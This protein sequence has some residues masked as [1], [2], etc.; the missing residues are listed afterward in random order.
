M[1][2]ICG[3]IGL[4]GR[5]W[6]VGDLD[7][8]LATLAPL[9]PDGG[10]R[11]AGTA[12]RCGVAVAAALRHAVPEDGFDVQP[13][14]NP[15]ET[16]A[17]VADLRLDNRDELSGLLGVPDSRS[18]P[19]SAFVLAGYERW[20]E[21]VLERMHGE[22]ALAIVDRRRGG[23]LLARDHVGARPLVVHERPHVVAFAS[24]ALALTGLEG[25]GHALDVRRAVEVLALA[26]LSERTFVQRVR[27]VPPATTLW[28]DAAG[29]RRRTWWQPD[30]FEIVDLGSAAAHEEELRE[31][32][33]VAV[34]ARLRTTRGVAASLSGGLDST[35]VAATAA[36]LLAPETL[37]TYTSAPPPGWNGD[38]PPGWDLDESPLVRKLAEMHPNMRPSFIH[39]P[40]GESVFALHDR[41][42]E[43]GSAPACN[44]CNMLW[45]T[46]M[47]TRAG[48]E[49]ASMMLS[50]ARGNLQFSADGPRWIAA[51]LH[52]GRVKTAFRE[53][54]KWNADAGRRLRT[55]QRDVVY[56]LLPE[57]AQRLA[58]VAYGKPERRAEWEASVALRPQF[59]A[60]LDMPNLLPALAPRPPDMRQLGIRHVQMVSTDCDL[61]AA[62]AIVTGVEERDPTGDRRVLAATIRQPEWVRR[63]D[64][65]T[66]AVVRGAM[67]DRLPPEI[68]NRTE[69]GEQLPDWFDVMTAARSELAYELE[70]LEEHD[71]S[72]L[73]IDTARLRKLGDGWPG[74]EAGTDPVTMRNYR[75][76]LFRA[77]LVSRYLRWFER[78]ARE[79]E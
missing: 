30:P 51:L 14:K 16:L 78:R 23:V 46:A 45:I 59:I 43:L 25:V 57:W 52:A 10:G 63:H 70:Q 3:V 2:A 26:F 77:L 33:D 74:L 6:A 60:E 40:R 5:P 13:A 47:R 64:R 11:W 76:A 53:A 27:W 7:G 50:G 55:L 24:N 65:T 69:R 79:R 9:G 72:R 49:G 19:D 4:D 32:L 66:R 17:L 21:S 42:W 41:L 1:S 75:L 71:T 31:A 61:Q 48:S 54:T 44:P 22:F 12:G 20:G 73:L 18:T 28:I 56:P 29:V 35:S 67:A 68:R 39:I 37:R 36:R 62:L 58:R 34:A 8:V 15:D 38:S